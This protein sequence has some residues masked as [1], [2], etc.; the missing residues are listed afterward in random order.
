M[1]ILGM[2][3]FEAQKATFQGFFGPTCCDGHMAPQH[4]CTT[5]TLKP[6]AIADYDCKKDGTD[7]DDADDEATCTS[8]GGTRTP[9]TCSTINMILGMPD[10]AAQKT[11]YQGFFGPTCCDGHMAPQHLCTT[12][13]LKPDAIANYECKKDGTDVDDADDEATC[14]SKGGTRTPNTCSKMNM[15]LG[16]PDFAPLKTMYQGY[17][18]PTC[19]DGYVA[20]AGADCTVDSECSNGLSCCNWDNAVG[21]AGKG[22]CGEMCITNVGGAG[23]DCSTEST[24]PAGM[25][26]FTGEELAI[27]MSNIAQAGLPPGSEA[28]CKK[29][30][31]VCLPLLVLGSQKSY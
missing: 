19:C 6:D 26:C 31:P 12:G 30:R 8:K 20:D 7:V 18:G 17:F 14:T 13:T 11:K 29:S 3:D 15:I 27:D 22:K 21:A 16:M 4:L 28:M 23:G 5:G 10:Y 25:H 9:N 2:P 1:G 24:K